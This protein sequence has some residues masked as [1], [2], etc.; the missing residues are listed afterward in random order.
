MVGI[1]LI[2]GITGF[3]KHYF[4]K[5]SKFFKGLARNA[6]AVYV[7]HTLI[8]VAMGLLL[9]VVDLDPFL[10]FILT[11]PLILALNF[12]LAHLFLKLPFVKRFL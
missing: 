11:A 12:L 9:S 8:L 7:I 4:S 5:Q 6:F 2:I 1:S 3:F 10:K